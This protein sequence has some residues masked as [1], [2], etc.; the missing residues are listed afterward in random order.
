MSTVHIDDKVDKEPCGYVVTHPEAIRARDCAIAMRCRAGRLRPAKLARAGSGAAQAAERC[1]GT[2]GEG[3][4]E[5]EEVVAVAVVIS[6][7][8]GTDGEEEVE[9]GRPGVEGMPG[10][11]C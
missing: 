8:V 2:A 3:R 5:D 11:C 10:G 9:W 6:V 1:A 4:D 7:A